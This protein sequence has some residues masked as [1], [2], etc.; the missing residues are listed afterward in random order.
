M[1]VD[2]LS[3]ADGPVPTYLDLIRHDAK[4]ITTALNRRN[5]MST[6]AIAVENVTVHYGEVLALDSA[7]LTL[8]HSSDLRP[9][10]DERFGQNP[11]LFKVYHGHGETRFW[12][13]SSSTESRP[14]EVCARTAGIADVPQSEDVDWAFPFVRPGRGDDGPLR[15]P[16]IHLLR[17]AK[18]TGTPSG[19]P[20]NGWN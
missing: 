20:W 6:P 9:G 5:V 2:S 4:V 13:G 19:T 14:V 12:L 11:T 15:A 18:P 10:G 8:Q 3:E 1:Y 17:G 7:S 16:R